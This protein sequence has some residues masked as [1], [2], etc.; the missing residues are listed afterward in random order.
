MVLRFIQAQEASKGSLRDG[1][2]NLG[3]L[4]VQLLDFYGNHFDPR[5]VGVSVMRNRGEGEYLQR[6]MGNPRNS[7]GAVRH[8]YDLSQLSPHGAWP[9]AQLHQAFPYGMRPR[10]ASE[11]GD[12]CTPID[13]YDLPP[14]AHRRSHQL[15]HALELPRQ[16]QRAASN[17][18][19]SDASDS[20][21]VTEMSD[22]GLY[23]M[24]RSHST[25]HSATTAWRHSV[26]GGAPPPPHRATKFWFD[27]LYIED[28]LRPSN[29]VG[30]NC[31]RIYA[32][33]QE[34]SKAR[35]LCLRQDLDTESLARH[36][37][38][39]LSRLLRELLLPSDPGNFATA[40]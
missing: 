23:T 6:S 28:P 36:E 34:F 24:G 38:P 29:N 7:S 3:A 37:Y 39:I 10:P 35:Q 19:V 20:F 13:P 21:S 25:T 33:Q 27:P 16:P 26:G 5:T 11:A 14:T 8:V 17:V 31:F 32:I 18:S 2:V 1:L 15:F 4:F 12:W 30:R 22:I 40:R 9:G